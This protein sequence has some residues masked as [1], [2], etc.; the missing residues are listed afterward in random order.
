M[1]LSDN[2]IQLLTGFDPVVFEKIV[3]ELAQLDNEWWN[4]LGFMPEEDEDEPTE[5]AEDKNT[6]KDS[7][8]TYIAGEI[9]QLVLYFSA[10]D[11]ENVTQRIQAVMVKTS[12][13][14]KG[15]LL[16]TM[17]LE[18]EKIHGLIA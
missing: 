12:S 6:L 11:Y 4:Q 3:D 2:E 10:S 13:A 15:E 1:M 9:K 17:I 16:K 7:Y 18:Y 14:S 5:R 8:N